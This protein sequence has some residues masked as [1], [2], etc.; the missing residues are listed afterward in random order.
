MVTWLRQQSIF[1]SPDLR[2]KPSS[3]PRRAQTA[4]YGKCSVLNRRACFGCLNF[5]SRR[6]RRDRRQKKNQVDSVVPNSFEKLYEMLIVRSPVRI[7]FAGGGTDLP[8]Y[9]E[10]F[11][12]LSSVQQ[13]ISTSIRS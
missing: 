13:S 9:Y 7:S 10:Q 2:G 5:D 12:E 11:G 8:A 1:R 4:H 6:T 3:R